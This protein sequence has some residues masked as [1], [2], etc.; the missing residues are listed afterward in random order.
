MRADFALYDHAAINTAV[1]AGA[2]V[3]VTVRMDPAAKTAIAIIA[4]DAWTMVEYT[5][6]I[7]SRKKEVRVPGGLGVHRIPELNPRQV[8]QPTLFDTCQHIEHDF[9]KPP[10]FF[11]KQLALF[12]EPSDANRLVNGITRRTATGNHFAFTAETHPDGIGSAE[13]IQ[14]NV[15]PKTD[16]QV[17]RRA[18]RIAV[19]AIDNVSS[20][21]VP[22]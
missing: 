18:V 13:V 12:L 17:T 9:Y 15:V 6:A 1:K 14:T 7:R 22:S 16:D 2:D 19:N 21:G 10:V 3:S 11:T 4:D 8:D 20:N 5:D